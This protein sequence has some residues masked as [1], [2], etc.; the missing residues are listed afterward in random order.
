ML[1]NLLYYSKNYRRKLEIYGS[2]TEM[3]QI[4]DLTITTEIEYIIQLKIENILTVITGL[5]IFFTH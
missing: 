3:N 5:N 2:I 1:Y 4:L